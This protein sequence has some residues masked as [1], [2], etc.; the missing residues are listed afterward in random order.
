VSS[1][2]SP[3]A[4]L[5]ALAANLGIAV[6]KFVAYGFTGSS[7]M[8]SEGVHSLADSGNQ[9][10]LLLGAKRARRAPTPEHPFGYGRTRYIYAFIVSIVL[11]TLGGLFALYE[12]WHK[13]MHPERLTSPAWAF[14]VLGVS[15]VLEALSLRTAAREAGGHRRGVSWAAFIRATK[16]PELAVI[17]LEDLGALVGLVFAFAGVTLAV[18]TGNGRW[19]G[20]GSLS[21]GLLLVVIAT[22][23]ARE[24]A[25]LLV[26]EAAEPDRV[27]AIREALEAGDDIE[28]VI[29]LRTMH[30]GPDELL[31]GAKVSVNHDD[32]AT[33][34]AR[35]IDAAEQRVRQVVPIATIIYLEPDIDRTDR[36]RT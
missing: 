26:G 24:M 33:A 35:A 18:V 23:L 1:S 13:L 22:Y 21:I 12:G 30:L 14:G 27:A 15:L 4:V 7:S 11:F 20:V 17:L 6:A 36:T 8:A 5:A 29:H 9:L 32:T 16:Q 25:S 28:R 19:D 2:E 3:K 31:V 10:L 34:V